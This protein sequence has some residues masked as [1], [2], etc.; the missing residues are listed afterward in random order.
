MLPHGW[1]KTATTLMHLLHSVPPFYASEPLP[2][3]LY[4]LF[5]CRC[6][7]GCCRD[8][9]N[10]TL[11]FLISSTWRINHDQIALIIDPILKKILITVALEPRSLPPGTNLMN[12]LI[13]ISCHLPLSYRSRFCCPSPHLRHDLIVRV[14]A[15][16]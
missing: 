15:C 2:R 1:G 10:S 9:V 8:L 16:P 13:A 11:I 3:S 12:L 6:G 4:L 14:L 5:R 7:R